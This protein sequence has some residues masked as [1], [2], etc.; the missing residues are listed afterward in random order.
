MC[1]R[2]RKSAESIYTHKE[3]YEGKTVRLDQAMAQWQPT[4][5][6]TRCQHFPWWILWFIWPAFFMFKWLL[7]LVIGSAATTLQ[8]LSAISGP[9]LALILIGAGVTLLYRE[10]TRASRERSVS[11]Y[12]ATPDET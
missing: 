9:L 10:R 3:V 12:N 11:S 8:T 1:C 7:P 5:T 2:K 6:T 4:A